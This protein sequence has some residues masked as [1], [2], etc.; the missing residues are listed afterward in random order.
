MVFDPK[1]Q[2]RIPFRK[3]ILRASKSLIIAIC[4]LDLVIN[5]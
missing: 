5:L 4:N 3:I 1:L 2:N